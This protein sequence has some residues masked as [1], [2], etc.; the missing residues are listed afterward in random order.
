VIT[1][2][3]SLTDVAFEVCTALDRAGTTAVLTGGS[4]ATFYAPHAYESDDLDFVV[5]LH[6][7]GGE[8]AL[9]ALGYQ[10]QVDYYIH[11]ASR[12][13]LEFPPGPLMIGDDHIRQWNT[14][15]RPDAQLA[16]VLAPTDCC[17]DRLAAFLFWN[18]FRGLDQALAVC[19]ARPDVDLDVVRDWC[20]RS[21]HAAKWDLFARRLG[22]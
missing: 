22:R 7:G 2:A 4:A 17:R 18:D 3:S 12:F 15:E 20:T 19:R 9:R 13:P 1:T 8:L 14:V 16:H 21:H 10:R 5:T 6:G 11:P